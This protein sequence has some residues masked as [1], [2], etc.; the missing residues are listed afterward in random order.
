MHF[1][2]VAGVDR[3][4]MFVYRGSRGAVVASMVATNGLSLSGVILK[5]GVYDF[6][7]W[8]RSRPWYDGIK[9]TMIWELGWLSEEKLKERS[10]V[11]S[12]D[13]I[14]APVL[15]IHGS[16]DDRA[17]LDI[18]EKFASKIN[19]A[20]GNAKLIKVES[21]HIIPMPQVVGYMDEFM[22]LH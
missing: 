20:G 5:S 2:S 18:A 16:H 3:H 17:P 12:A 7:E 13:K 15:I 1:Q 21:E 4:R 8:L 10:A 11:Y 19:G 22:K 9:L 6:V 14:K